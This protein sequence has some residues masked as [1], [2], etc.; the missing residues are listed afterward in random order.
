MKEERKA[1]SPDA[2]G[3]LFLLYK[4]EACFRQVAKLS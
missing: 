4:A 1:P 2:A 3:K